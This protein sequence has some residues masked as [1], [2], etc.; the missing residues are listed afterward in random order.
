MSHVCAVP[1]CG[2]KIEETKLM[3]LEHWKLVPSFTQRQVTVA[4][5]AIRKAGTSK[6]RLEA[7]ARY[8]ETRQ[9]AVN[10]L[11]HLEPLL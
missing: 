10:S 8:R 2:W 3:C 11:K 6:T 5:A 4:W 7:I 1:G 9:A